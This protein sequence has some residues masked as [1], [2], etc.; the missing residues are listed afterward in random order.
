MRQKLSELFVETGLSN[1][2]FYI[3]LGDHGYALFDSFREQCFEQFINTG[4]AEQS[5]VAYSAGL[6][7]MGMRVLVYGLASFIPIRVLEFIKMDVCYEQLPVIFIGDGVSL[8]Y[9]T[10]GASHQCGE[11][12]AVLRS[13]PN[14]K[15][16][17]PAD[18]YELEECYNRAVEDTKNASYIRI[19]K[20]DR[21]EVH[22]DITEVK[23]NLININN[24]ESH[25][26]IISTGA[27]VSTSLEIANKKNWTCFSAPFISDLFEA[28]LP[29]FIEKYSRIIVIEEHCTDGG[30]GS[31]VGELLQKSLNKIGKLEIY[32][33]GKKFTTIASDYESALSEH[34]L[35]KNQLLEVLC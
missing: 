10:L 33:L 26:A 7:K 23:K 17:S 8:V 21:P 9:S 4:I 15:I 18:K 5:T 12:M 25:T 31:I 27:M 32:G 35:T 19:G 11:D 22:S 30:L 20:S 2:D 1:S 28:G 13:I 24:R 3:L 29:D 6:T 14:L 34:G 16:Y